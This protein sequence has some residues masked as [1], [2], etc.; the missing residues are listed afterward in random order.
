[1][2]GVVGTGAKPHVPG[3]AGVGRFLIADHFDGLIGKVFRQMVAFFGAI[4]LFNGMVVFSQIGIKLVGF[5][6]NE[7]IKTIVTLLQRP[8][9][10]VGTGREVGFGHVVVFT[11]PKSAPTIVVQYLRH[12]SR[13]RWQLATVTGEAI[14]AFGNGT[15]AV[16]VVVAACIDAR[17]GRRTKGNSVPL[18]IG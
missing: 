1:M 15:H 2:R 12:G 3:F 7:A 18:G 10:F 16:E 4:R 8:L 5:A 13:L 6:P 17:P 9:A 14:G 11:Q